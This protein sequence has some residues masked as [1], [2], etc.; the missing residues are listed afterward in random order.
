MKKEIEMRSDTRR[1]RPRCVSDIII[2]CSKLDVGCSMLNP[3]IF[4]MRNAACFLFQIY[5]D[6]LKQAGIRSEE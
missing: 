4:D 2:R 1:K 5:Y 3:L 6:E